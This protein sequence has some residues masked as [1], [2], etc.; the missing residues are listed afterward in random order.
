MRV[1]EMMTSLIMGFYPRA[2]ACYCLPG[3]ECAVDQFKCSNGRCIQ[4]EWVC[5]S[6]GDC[7]D[8]SDEATPGCSELSPTRFTSCAFVSYLLPI[9]NIILDIIAAMFDIPDI[10]H[11]SESFCRQTTSCYTQTVFSR[12]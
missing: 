5:D 9:C 2:R 11:S 10:Y 7:A 8:N 6:D 12:T 1:R 3:G 4:E